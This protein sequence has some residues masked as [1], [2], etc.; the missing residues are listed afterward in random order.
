MNY[1]ELRKFYFDNFSLG[2]INGNAKRSPIENRIVLICLICYVTHKNKLKNPD[3]NHY[4]IIM[5]LSQ[6][7]GL[8]ED[9]IKA[10]SIICEDFSY[11][12]DSYPTFGLEGKDILKEI[13]AILSSF[14]PF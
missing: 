3:I 4:Q 6:N 14:C 5:K 8:P 7:L 1:S 10:L 2:Y 9:F 12:C 11:S 13:T